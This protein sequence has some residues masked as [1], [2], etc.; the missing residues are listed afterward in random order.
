[1]SA[2]AAPAP[3]TDL[4]AVEELLWR[5][6]SAVLTTVPAALDERLR[7]ATGLNHFQ[8]TVLD[9]LS[10]QD[11]G[12]LQLTQIARDNDSSLSR[13]SHAITRLEAIGY[14][15]RATCDHDRRASWAVLTDQG[16]AIVEHARGEY[17]RII[18]ETLLDHVP[19]GQR[20]TLTE[21]L[22]ALVPAEGAAQ[23][24]SMDADLEAQAED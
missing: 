16:A 14:V 12:R 19:T 15:E 13:L 17:T 22:G 9:A 8:Y 7:S 1:M 3:S 4:S 11:G 23:C 24:A 6:F 18:R 2:E 5:R 10:R 20:D 21:L